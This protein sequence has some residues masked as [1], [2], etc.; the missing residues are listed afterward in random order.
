[1]ERL[2]DRTAKKLARAQEKAAR[3]SENA[4][5]NSKLSSTLAGQFKTMGDEVRRFAPL[6]AGMLST[7]AVTNAAEA[8]TRFGNQ[9][10]VAG[11]SGSDLAVVQ[12]ELFKIAQANGVELESLGTLYGRAAQS[13]TELGASQGDLLKFTEGV[14]VAL[15]VQGGDASQA[16]GALLQLSQALA[17]GTVR[18]EEF[19]S[20]NEGA[21]P[22]LDAVAAGSERFKG[23]V[24]TLR[25]EVMAGTVSSKEF[26]AAF[27]EGSSILED[28]AA[29]AV[30]TLGQSFVVLSNA[31]TKYIGEANEMTGVTAVLVQ[32]IKS[33]A[34]NLPQV[35]TAL[36]TIAAVYA[37]SFI[38]AVARGAVALG[39]KTVAMI[40]AQRAM[41]AYGIALNGGSLAMGT[42]TVA[43][44]GLL[45]VLGGP[46]GLALTAI[47]VGLGYFAIESA[48]ADAEAAKLKATSD[49]NAA[50]FGTLQSATAAA[51]AENTGLTNSQIIAMNSANGLKIEVHELAN[52]HYRAAA[53]ARAHRIEEQRLA[54][55]SARKSYDELKDRYIAQEGGG[56]ISAAG[57]SGGYTGL[58]PNIANGKSTRQRRDEAI[59]RAK[60]TPE[61]QQLIQASRTLQAMQS[62]KDPYKFIP[63]GASPAAA[64]S[65][66]AGGGKGGGR[67]GGAGRQAS[68]GEDETANVQQEILRLKLQE[69]TDLEER[70]TIRQSLLDAEM[71]EREDAINQ[72]VQQGQ[73]TQAG[74]DKVL[75]EEGRLRIIKQLALYN[76]NEK[77]LQERGLAL[78]QDR[79]DLAFDTLNAEADDLEAIAAHSRN[80]EQIHSLEWQALDKRQRA[81]EMA[82][83]LSQQQYALDLQKL[84]LTQ[85]EIDSKLAQS[86]TNFNTRQNLQSDDLAGK[87]AGDDPDIRTRIKNAAGDFGTLN[88]Q[89]TN[90]ATGA[91]NSITTGIADAII[92]AN[93][94]KEA[95]TDMANAIIKSLIE[96][97]IRF[98]IF[99]AIGRAF[100]VQG[101]GKAA[102]GLGGSKAG[103]IEIG[104]KAAGTNNWKGGL[105]MVGE[106]GP[107][108]LN[109]PSGAG[110]MPNHLLRN[111][112][113]SNFAGASQPST[114]LTV[115]NTVYAD[116][117][118]LTDWVKK[119]VQAGTV[120][121]VTNA[122]KI[123]TRGIQRTQ[124]N[125]FIG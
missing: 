1:M 104:G 112:L 33:L 101:L 43:A 12:E 30:F 9:L 121:A 109:L 15:R 110:V 69:S 102:I 5:K 8:W 83:D 32:A 87:Q 42:A 19:N 108:L 88:E 24:S 117:A 80:L 44:R 114:Q 6:L 103:N 63:A 81:D 61:Y 90:I 38:P 4:W 73:L 2:N 60:S 79:V 36:A 86:R 23:S 58:G 118:V 21:K 10:K 115:N 13:A 27:L 99:E 47:T 3:S 123:T 94:L 53:A 54:V 77:E 40:Q 11:V 46:L 59:Y 76:E 82:F 22:I 106:K 72:K 49:A 116:D 31:F 124:A 98:L 45:A 39:T 55:E 97:A 52:A 125:S 7:A 37:A 28:K 26:F 71:E 85:D 29:N 65:A 120:D 68:N 66:S 74:A 48:K 18:A 122:Q 92:G 20:I 95:F 119:Q 78:E 34:D 75:A 107:E 16:S 100:G 51:S 70:A 84:G 50:A 62:E 35:A 89:L 57:L 91:L 17:G 93:S 96:M 67:K 41:I 64:P 113:N 111:S 14:S 105:T 56:P 25:K